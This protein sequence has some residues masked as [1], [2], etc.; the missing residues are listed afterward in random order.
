MKFQVLALLLALC[1]LVLA[2]AQ[3][4]KQYMISFENDTPA[5]VI[6]QARATIENAVCYEA[7]GCLSFCANPRFGREVRYCMNLVCDLCYMLLQTELLTLAR[8]HK[9]CLIL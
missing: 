1:V 5:S 6:D 3:S 2:V 7:L 8:I 9:V 4:K